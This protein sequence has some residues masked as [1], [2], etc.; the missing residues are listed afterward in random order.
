MEAYVG[1]ILFT[2]LKST[3]L[4]HKNLKK[5]FFQKKISEISLKK[6]EVF[7]NPK[8]PNIQKNQRSDIFLTCIKKK[9]GLTKQ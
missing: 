3:F 2:L 9:F 5:F 8:G 1:T 4:D 6:K 7:V